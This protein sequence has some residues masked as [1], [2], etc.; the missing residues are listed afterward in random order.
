M[1]IQMNR[2]PGHERLRSTTALPDNSRVH[3]GHTIPSRLQSEKA[4][5]V[6]QNCNC[7][8]KTELFEHVRADYLGGLL[9]AY[10]LG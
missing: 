2:T 1:F 5:T 6:C 3:V 4:I 9:F 7:K 8:S 10:T